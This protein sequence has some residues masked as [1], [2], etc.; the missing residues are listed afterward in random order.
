MFNDEQA[1]ERRLERE[2]RETRLGTLGNP[3]GINVAKVE[4]CWWYDDAGLGLASTTTET[5]A[6]HFIVA[7]TG[8]EPE[9]EG[10]DGTIYAVFESL[11]HAAM[12]ARQERLGFAGYDITDI[13]SY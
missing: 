2:A 9:C 5:H 13:S 4:V 8:N 1:T 3:N 11:T 7:A 10:E 6:G 12:Q